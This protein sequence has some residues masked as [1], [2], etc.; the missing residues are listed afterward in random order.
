MLAA[1]PASRISLDR[2]GARQIVEAV[3]SVI[4]ERETVRMGIHEIRVAVG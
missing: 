1:V 4:E 3:D 2:D